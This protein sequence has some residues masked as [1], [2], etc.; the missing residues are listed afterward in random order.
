MVLYSVCVAGPLDGLSRQG[1]EE[2]MTPVSS[3]PASPEPLRRITNLL[4]RTL[5]SDKS[6]KVLVAVGQVAALIV[7]VI[8]SYS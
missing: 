3:D 4:T 5:N 8:R 7:L 1:G 2:L 6:F